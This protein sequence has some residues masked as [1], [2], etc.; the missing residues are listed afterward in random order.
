MLAFKCDNVNFFF[1]PK[2]RKKNAE[3]LL[4]SD[5]FS[6]FDLLVLEKCPVETVTQAEMLLP[7]NKYHVNI[8]LLLDLAW[9]CQKNS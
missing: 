6:Q 2:I 5:M 9:H 1:S 3:N 7:S 4:S 8:T